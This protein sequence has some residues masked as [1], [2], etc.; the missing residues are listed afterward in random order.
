MCIRDSAYTSASKGVGKP[1]AP[2]RMTDTEKGKPPVD[3]DIGAYLKS[4]IK[5]DDTSNDTSTTKTGQGGPIIIRDKDS[6]VVKKAAKDYTKFVKANPVLGGVTSLAAYDIGRGIFSKIM[7][8]RGPGVQGGR[9][10][11]RS[12][13]R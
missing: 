2:I 6:S 1:A 8:L 3:T 12:A 5:K 7:N 10:G 9:A 13:G 4:K 11:F